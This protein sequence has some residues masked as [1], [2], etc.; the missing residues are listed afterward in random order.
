[1]TDEERLAL[2]PTLTSKIGRRWRD[3]P[4]YLAEVR[5]ILIP[6]QFSKHYRVIHPYTMCSTARLRGL[7][8]AVQYVV[9][10][11]IE[12]DVVECGTA[13]GGS[14]AL[15]GLT[16]NQLH[17]D[18]MLWVFDSFEGLPPPSKA[19]PDYESAKY[20]T[21]KCRGELPEVENLFRRCSILE[22]SQLIKGLFQDTLSIARVNKIAVL[23]IDG[24]WY[25]SVKV[26]LDYLYDCVTPG[27]VIQID[28]YGHWAGARQAVSE[29]FQK[30]CIIPKLRY[31]DY[32]GR[33]F[34]K[35]FYR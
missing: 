31:L 7:Y 25:E 30:R 3:I 21:G 15:M 34:I 2:Y 26:C 12:G 28:D 24:D 17:S 10:R 18:R 16:L 8:Q 32:T 5:E 19:N 9:S 4:W 35:P 20:W 1:M 13:R 29:F 23:H 33:Q 11:N 14:A 6:G 22:R 27:G